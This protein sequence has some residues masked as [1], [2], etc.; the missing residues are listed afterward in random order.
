MFG[1]LFLLGLLV[2]AIQYPLISTPIGIQLPYAGDAYYHLRRIWFTVARFPESLAYDRYVSF[3]QGSQIVWPS[4]FDW[5]IALAIR[6]FV[7][8]TDQA[9]VESVAIWAP[10]VLGAFTT[11]LV[12]LL[13]NR[14]YGNLAGWCA[15]LLYAVLPMSFTFSRLGMIDHHVA[16]ALLSTA[17]LWIACELFGRDDRAHSW[18]EALIQPTARPSVVLGIA[19]GIGI[20]ATVGTWPGALLHVLVLQV[21]FG[22]RWLATSDASVARVRALAFALSQAVA[23]ICL[24]PFCLGME[25]HHYGAWSPLVHSNL[26]PVYFASAALMLRIAQIMHD[27]TP[28][29]T[30]LAR[31][32]G[33][34]IAIVAIGLIVA[35]GTIPAIREAI[36]FAGSWFSGEDELLGAINELKPILMRSDELDLTFPLAQFGA[37]FLFLPA[38]WLYLAWRAIREHDAN[39][40][41]FVVWTAAFIVLTLQQWRFG[42]TLAVAHSVSIG[43]VLAAWLANLRPRLTSSS[44]RPWIEAIAVAGLVLWTAALFD[45]MYRPI[46][47]SSIVALQ[48]ENRSRFGPLH[49]RVRIF[50][51]AGRWLAENT[52]ATAGYLDAEVTPG[53]GVLAGWSK[54]HLLRYRSER[55]MVQDNFGS[56]ARRESFEAAQAYF[57]EKDE[58]A[59]IAILDRLRVRYVVGSEA[60]AGRFSSLGAEAM[61][62]RLATAFGSVMRGPTGETIPGLE[63]HRLIFHAHSAGPGQRRPLHV[64]SPATGLG[65]WEVVPGAWIEGSAKP[66]SAIDLLLGIETSAKG[67]DTYHQRSITDAAG[68]YRFRVPYPTDTRFSPAIRVA[69]TYQISG[70]RGRSKFV[71]READI[72]AGS[73]LAGPDL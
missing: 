40:G 13:A 7:D 25:W 70:P 38:I 23:A 19:L 29:G 67:A 24:A 60:G 44:W 52:P 54:G 53:Y 6:P 56:Y 15:G 27:R 14:L 12:A 49:P 21:A 9:A 30:T 22:L 11:G 3:P 32:T 35:L 71:V 37:G 58:E 26:Q 46:V 36:L 63:R 50:D 69:P 47:K 2:R 18:V 55:P 8:P 66:G 16:V 43:A 4:T 28:L 62:F 51:E 73:R 64:A 72:Q 59:A 34:A 17:M 1:G 68:R 65:V 42:N 31:R 57:S 20:A 61:V 48:N 5:W 39:Q 33:S 45:K 10:A 41:L